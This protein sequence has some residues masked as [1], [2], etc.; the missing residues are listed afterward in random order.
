MVFFIYIRLHPYKRWYL[1]LFRMY[2][3]R[4]KTINPSHTNFFFIFFFSLHFSVSLCYYLA[5]FKLDS[6][7]ICRFLSINFR[8]MFMA[9]LIWL[10][11]EQISDFIWIFRY[12]INNVLIVL[13]VLLLLLPQRSPSNR[14][15]LF[16][17]REWTIKDCWWYDLKSLPISGNFGFILLKILLHSNSFKRHWISNDQ[18]LKME[19]N[20]SKM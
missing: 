19:G 17:K 5:L 18:W 15:G 6:R 1:T 7:L 11:T 4:C 13:F 3:F 9:N 14:L 20:S 16:K 2:N 10:C 8:K 12:F